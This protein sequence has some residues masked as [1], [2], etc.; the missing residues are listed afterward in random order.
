M[1]PVY[2]ICFYWEGDRWKSADNT[3]TPSDASYQRH[4][5]RIGSVDMQLASDYV[6]CLYHG[7]KHN[8]SRPFKFICFTNESL[9]L[10]KGIEVREF[11]MVTTEGVLPRLYMFSEESGLWGRQV[12]CLDIDVI[13]VGNLEKMLRYEGLFCARSKFRTSEQWKLDGDVMSFRAGPEAEAKFWLP[14]IKDVPA[15]VKLTQGRERYWIRHVAGGFADRWDKVSP[16][17]VVSYKWH[18]KAYRRIPKEVCVISCHGK[19]RPHQVT[20]QLLRLHWDG[21]KSN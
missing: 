3:D 12:L 8:M 1:K 6:N 17:A 11:P 14:F 4:L 20:N 13:I 16:G 7:V 18:A 19:P 15:A 2:V 10:E 5:K 21:W 9:T